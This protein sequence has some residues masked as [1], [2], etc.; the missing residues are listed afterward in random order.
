M[1]Q[2]RDGLKQKWEDPVHPGQWKKELR[3]LFFLHNCLTKDLPE[4][5]SETSWW[6]RGSHLLRYPYTPILPYKF[7]LHDAPSLP[8]PSLQRPSFW[9]NTGTNVKKRCSHLSSSTRYLK[10]QN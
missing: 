9:F 5:F 6:F 2:T 10:R 3:Q 4:S 1:R 7:L 8:T